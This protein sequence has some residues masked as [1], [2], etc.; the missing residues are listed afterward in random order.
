[1]QE[2]DDRPIPSLVTHAGAAQLLAGLA[3]LTMAALAGAALCLVGSLASTSLCAT[4]GCPCPI[5]GA[6]GIAPIVLLPISLAEIGVGIYTIATKGRKPQVNATL[7][8]FELGH[9]V[10]GAVPAVM[11]GLLVRS[12]LRDPDV[13]AYLED[14]EL[15]V[16]V[17]P[18]SG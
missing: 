12:Y 5:G 14:R 4:F 2:F 6:I 3:N 11:A 15:D 16:L 17:E 18:G 10:L 9:A 1:M 8:L 13:V 7:A